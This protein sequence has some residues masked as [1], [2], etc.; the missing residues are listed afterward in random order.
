MKGL[1]E[2]PSF[3]AGPE[4]ARCSAGRMRSPMF[5]LGALLLCGL[6]RASHAALVLW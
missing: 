5:W 4:G 1:H 2:E 6:F 3:E